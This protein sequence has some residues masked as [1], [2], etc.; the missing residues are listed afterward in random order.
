VGDQQYF[1]TSSPDL[2]V[3]CG[4]DTKPYTRSECQLLFY[5]IRHGDIQYCEKKAEHE[6]HIQFPGYLSASDD[7]GEGI[8][9]RSKQDPNLSAILSRQCLLLIHGRT[10]KHLHPPL[11]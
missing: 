4:H 5:G 9:I 1:R 6:S 10:I 8:G 2:S 11:P 3:F 7:I